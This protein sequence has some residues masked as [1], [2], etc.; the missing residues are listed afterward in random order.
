M[1]SIA[2]GV[3]GASCTILGGLNKSYQECGPGEEPTK[4]GCRQAGAGGST[5]TTTGSGG[6]GGTGGCPATSLVCDGVCVDPQTDPDHCGSCDKWCLS[7]VACTAGECAICDQNT[8]VD[9]CSDL[10]TDPNHCAGCDKS[11]A[12]NGICVGGG[13]ACPAGTDPCA[14]DPADEQCTD[15]CADL[16]VD[17]RHCKACGVACKANE[18]CGGNGCACPETVTVKTCGGVCADTSTDPDHCGDCSVSNSNKCGA[19][20]ACIAGKCVAAPLFAGTATGVVT[21]L[22]VDADA[23]YWTEADWMNF[24]NGYV[25]RQLHE[26]SVVETLATGEIEPK[27]I[28]LDGRGNVYWAS[29]GAADGEYLKT[30]PVNGG[31]KKTL[32]TA[33][34]V[35]GLASDGESLFWVTFT[36]GKVWRLELLPTPAQTAVALATGQNTPRGLIL[37]SKHIFWARSNYGE[38][39][40]AHKDGKALTGLVGYMG[41]AINELAA[42]DDTVYW[43]GNNGTVGRVPINGGTAFIGGR[44]N[45]Q[46]LGKIRYDKTGVYWANTSAAAIYRASLDLRTIAIVARVPDAA[47]ASGFGAALA[48][49][50]TYL[51]FV[52]KDGIHRLKKPAQ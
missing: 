31:T 28:A 18:V 38:I 37:D 32:A 20:L 5:S 3:T 4:T 45:G 12:V 9:A 51:Y 14:C 24:S 43:A 49:G 6:S 21:D 23:V 17:P 46:S 29:I 39:A 44:N 30:V 11:C 47:D 42:S 34:N 1:L 50:E 15:A 26:G 7:G 48:I 36:E 40:Q 25:R 19:E 22:A 10:L 13:C 41:D 2:L 27:H 52:A 8:C 35:H 16:D 33:E